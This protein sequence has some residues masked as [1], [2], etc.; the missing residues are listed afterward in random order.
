MVD[1]DHFALNFAT[2]TA[3]SGDDSEAAHAIILT[4]IEE[5]EKNADSMKQ[6][7]KSR[8]VD[9]LLLWHISSF[10]F[11]IDWCFWIFYSY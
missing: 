3:F 5:T 9:E 8:E 2:L 1:N 4:F 6:A 11:Y 10:P 7:L